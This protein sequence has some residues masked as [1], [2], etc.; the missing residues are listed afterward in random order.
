[1]QGMGKWYR[2]ATSEGDDRLVG[3]SDAYRQRWLDWG[4]ALFPGHPEIAGVATNAALDT[5]Q[6]GG[7]PEEAA[8]AARREVRKQFPEEADGMVSYQRPGSPSIR[9]QPVSVS[10]GEAFKFGIF[11]GCGFLLVLVLLLVLL[12]STRTNFSF[13]L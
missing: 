6:Q 1:M 2:R 12:A 4:A 5:M 3:D 10:A 11:A 9:P 7:T 13:H 8:A